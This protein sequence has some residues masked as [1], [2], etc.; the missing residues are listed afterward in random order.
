MKMEQQ[1][2]KRKRKNSQTLAFVV[3]LAPA[4]SLRQANANFP[5]QKH[6]C[7]TSEVKGLVRK[8]PGSQE[9][10]G[11]VLKRKDL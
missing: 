7:S 1:P 3:E 6:L 10:E 11:L 5:H 2:P 9:K 4:H 8:S